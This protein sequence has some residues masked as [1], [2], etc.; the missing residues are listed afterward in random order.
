MSSEFTLV[1]QGTCMNPPE[2]NKI[3]LEFPSDDEAIIFYETML[4]I[5]RGDFRLENIYGSHRKPEED[6][7]C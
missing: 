4:A 2:G 5:A 1:P 7:T 6:G 3:L